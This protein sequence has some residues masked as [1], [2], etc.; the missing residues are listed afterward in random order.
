MINVAQGDLHVWHSLFKSLH[1]LAER[2]TANDWTSA[3]TIFFESLKNAHDCSRVIRTYFL[4]RLLRRLH[5]SGHYASLWEREQCLKSRRAESAT[6]LSHHGLFAEDDVI[7][8]SWEAGSSSSAVCSEAVDDQQ[9]LQLLGSFPWVTVRSDKRALEQW[10]WKAL[11]WKMS[12]NGFQSSW[13]PI[14]MPP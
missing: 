7:T 6:S 5:V 4:L 9:S 1:S 8:E 12:L 3:Y 14:P 13:C 2:D 11:H 10:A